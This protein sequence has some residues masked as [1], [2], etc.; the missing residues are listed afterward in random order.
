M[1]IG[2]DLMQIEAIFSYFTFHQNGWYAPSQSTLWKVNLP[3]WIPQVC[4]CCEHLPLYHLLTCWWTWPAHS[5]A[6]PTF[7]Y[8]KTRAGEASGLFW[9]RGTQ[10]AE[11]SWRAEDTWWG[12]KDLAGLSDQHDLPMCLPSPVL[13]R[14]LPNGFFQPVLPKISSFQPL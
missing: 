11:A 8:V 2:E 3:S 12:K 7:H 4:V 13:D 5:H 10:H 14:I 1:L 6:I 9:C